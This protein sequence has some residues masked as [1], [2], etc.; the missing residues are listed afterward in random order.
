[1]NKDCIIEDLVNSISLEIID[2]D[3]KD[4]QDLAHILI[5]LENSE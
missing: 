2:I 1:M 3:E 4:N 5:K